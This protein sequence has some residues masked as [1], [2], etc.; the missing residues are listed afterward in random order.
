MIPVAALVTLSLGLLV[1]HEPR[2]TPSAIP[3]E[4]LRRHDRPDSLYVAL[5]CGWRSLAHLNLPTPQGAGDGEGTLIAP[6]WVL[7]AAHVA[8]EVSPGHP[9]TVGGADH[10][11]DSIVLHPDWNDGPHDLALVRL[12]TPVEDVRP[13][14]LYRESDELDRVVVMVGW[15]DFGTGVTGP[16]GNDLRV[17]GA[18]NR[19]DEASDLWLKL[20]FDPPD[21]PRTTE[22]EGVSG[23]GDSGG[24]A[25]LEGAAEETLMGVGSGSSTR[26]AAGPGQ[27]GV[28]EYYV[29]VSRYLDWIEGITGGVVR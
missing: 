22:L 16:E 2:P 1:P 19:V 3:P 5:G 12:A 14:R 26:G 20:R 24:P 10:V 28:V 4:I 21:H 6:R 15:G 25:Y 9:V 23:P 11:I 18:T 17:R 8:A 7:T 13:A 29:R 27:Y